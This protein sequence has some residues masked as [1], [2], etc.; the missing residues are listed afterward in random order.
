MRRCHS[1]CMHISHVHRLVK[2]ERALL[3]WALRPANVDRRER[4]SWKV[5]GYVCDDYWTAS[6]RPKGNEWATA[7]LRGRP[8]TSGRS[9]SSEPYPWAAP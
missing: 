3:A 1:L 9:P 4:E 7:P 8:A 6:N 2:V 5:G